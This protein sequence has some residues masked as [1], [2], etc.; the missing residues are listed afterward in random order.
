MYV[1][2]TLND[3]FELFLINFKFKSLNRYLVF[4][5]QYMLSMFTFQA[6]E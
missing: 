4:M 3:C 6:C 2:N 1:V 5:F